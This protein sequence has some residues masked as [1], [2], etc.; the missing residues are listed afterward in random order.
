MEGKEISERS[1]K[2]SKALEGLSQQE[3]YNFVCRYARIMEDIY[4]MIIKEN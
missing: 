2:I 3:A 4:P 1:S